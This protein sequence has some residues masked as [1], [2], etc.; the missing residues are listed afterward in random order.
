M[1]II[2]SGWKCNLGFVVGI[3]SF[4]LVKGIDVIGE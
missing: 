4:M 1:V 2:F 3:F